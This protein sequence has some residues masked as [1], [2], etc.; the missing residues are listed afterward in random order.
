MT[1]ENNYR[2]DCA[3]GSTELPSVGTLSMTE[4]SA[5]QEP[6]QKCTVIP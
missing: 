4:G 2:F 1:A 5:W 3:A 6:S